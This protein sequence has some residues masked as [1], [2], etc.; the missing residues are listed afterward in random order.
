[1]EP[2]TSEVRAVYRHARISPQKARAVTR[3]IQGRPV[4]NAGSVNAT[5]GI[6][7]PV[8]L[9][10]ARLLQGLSV[11][12]EYGASATYLSEMAG[13]T[14]R[15]FWSS[16]QYVTLIMGQLIALGVLIL[17]H[18]IGRAVVTGDYAD[19]A[20]QATLAKYFG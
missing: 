18:G 5:I 16:F 9:L 11:G 17:L 14:H 3:E 6:A 15:G 1:M 7:A 10:L 2:K 20:L 13:Q 8:L 19:D 12:G 4:A